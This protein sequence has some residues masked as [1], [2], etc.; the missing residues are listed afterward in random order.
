MERRAFIRAGMSVGVLG[1]SGT[2]T[3]DARPPR[4]LRRQAASP[5]RLSS[6]ENPLGLAPA[7]RDAIIK[8][9]DEANRYPRLRTNLHEALARKLGVTTR[10]IVLGAGST[11]VLKVA[12]EEF[13]GPTGTGGLASP[14]FEDAEWYAGI[15]GVRIEKVPLRPDCSHDIPAMRDVA[16]RIE[17]PVCVYL[18]NPNNPTGTVTPSAEIDEWIGTAPERVAFVV[19]EAYIDFVE[20]PAYHSALPWIARR[21]NVL[22][23]RTFSKVHG[24]A[25]VRLGYGLVHE[26][27]V[28]ALRRRLVRMD[29]NHLALVGG[30][31][32]LASDEFVTR[33]LAVNRRGREI[34]YTCFRELG[35]E[36]LPSQ[37]NFVMHRINGDLPT[38]INRMREQGIQVGRPFPPMLDYNRVSIGLPEE[39]ERFAE[40]LRAFR[41]QGWV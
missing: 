17:G 28:E 40:A 22:V 10:N 7:A 36:S 19:D 30:L 41:R 15:G 27:G 20:D 4:P 38:H 23:T 31:A 35:L 39:M 11:E 5:I 34:A 9:L 3:L 37:T 26:D 16:A 8:G 29:A 25:G 21:P 24:M 14:T 33:S 2:R 6:N 13:A 1:L 18:C 32:S 12:V